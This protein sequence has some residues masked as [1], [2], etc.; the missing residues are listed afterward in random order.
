LIKRYGNQ[1]FN[2]K[3][4]IGDDVYVGTHVYLAA[5]GEINIGDGC[6]L[7]DYVNINDT[8]HG[9]DP[10]AGNIMQQNLVS[11]GPIRL[12]PNCFVG[13]RAAILPGVTLGRGCVVGINSVVTK[14]F[15]PYCMI[16]GAP[17]R[18]IRV[19]NFDI[20]SWVWVS[21]NDSSS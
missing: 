15:P 19:F 4:L 14:S 11:K 13:Y 9:M 21:T 3:I 8:S 1:T 7:S 6:V 18:V 12:E 10:T 17:A 5:T 2:P 16:A 20:K